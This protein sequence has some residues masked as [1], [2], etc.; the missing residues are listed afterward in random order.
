MASLDAVE[1]EPLPECH[2]LYTHPRVRLSPHG[3]WN[4]PGAAELLVEPFVDN[5]RRYRDGQPLLGI[6]D[7]EAVY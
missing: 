7:V 6:V 2:W 1:P 5:L 4:M 3:S